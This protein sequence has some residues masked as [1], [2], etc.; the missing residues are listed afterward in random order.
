MPSSDM[1]DTGPV[2]TLANLAGFVTATD[3]PARH[4]R[5]RCRAGVAVASTVPVANGYVNAGVPEPTRTDRR[6]TSSTA[7]GRSSTGSATP[8]SC[9]SSRDDDELFAACHRRR[10]HRGPRGHPGMVVSGPIPGRDR[11][12]GPPGHDAGRTRRP[13][14]APVRGRVRHAGPRLDARPPPD[15]RRA[16]A[17]LVGD[18]LRRYDRPGRRRG[19]LDRGTGGIYYVGTPPEHRGRGAAAADQPRGSPNE[20]ARRRGHVVTLEASAD[21]PA[22]L[23][24]ARLHRPTPHLRRCIFAR[25]GLTRVRGSGARSPSGSAGSGWPAAACAGRPTRGS[26]RS[27]PRCPS[28]RAISL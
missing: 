16:R 7:P 1:D 27:W 28:S 2:P 9:G 5:R 22:R 3:R 10:R 24:A 17:P 18:R 19:F 6:P 14:G 11:A 23:R 13:F 20:A 12:R 26:R 4:R 8:T 25:D 15:V 21:G